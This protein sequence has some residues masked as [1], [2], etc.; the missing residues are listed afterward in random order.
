MVRNERVAQTPFKVLA[1][2][3]LPTWACRPRTP[4]SGRERER[5][6]PRGCVHRRGLLRPTS[7][8]PHLP[9]FEQDVVHSSQ[10]HRSYLGDSA[11]NPGKGDAEV[12]GIR[13]AG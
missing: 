1:E 6:G 3:T 7:L 5:F 4:V 13:R 10:N 11:R 9:M 8:G 12:A 2:V